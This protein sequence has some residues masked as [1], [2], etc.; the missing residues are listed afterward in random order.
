MAAGRKKIKTTIRAWEFRTG[1]VAKRTRNTMALSK[2][3]AIPL[4]VEGQL[5]FCTPCNEVMPALA[6]RF[7]ARIDTEQHP[8]DRYNCR[9]VGFC[10]A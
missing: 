5:V 7:D 3:Q 10:I 4:L 9:G 2:I 1:D 8:A 6:Q